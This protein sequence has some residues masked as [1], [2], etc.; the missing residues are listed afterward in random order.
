VGNVEALIFILLERLISVDVVVR[1][2]LLSL[3]NFRNLY[4]VP[5]TLNNIKMVS[6]I[7]EEINRKDPTENVS[8]TLRIS[9]LKLIEDFKN[10]H[11]IEKLSPFLD[12]LIKEWITEQNNLE[13][14]GS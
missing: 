1:E 2:N 7:I 12:A 10:K 4:N 8:L 14:A 6:K 5:I 9:T 13:V 3:Y 11:K